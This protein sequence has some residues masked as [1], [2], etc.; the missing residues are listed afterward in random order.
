M[1]I[2]LQIEKSFKLLLSLKTGNMSALF[3]LGHVIMIH[4]KSI[5]VIIGDSATA[6]LR[7]AAIIGTGR[8]TATY[9]PAAFGIRDPAVSAHTLQS[10][11]ATGHV[12]RPVPRFHPADEH[13]GIRE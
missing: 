5:V 12:P 7:R 4:T 11:I 1:L 3:T 8:S 10:S 9:G 6:R 2:R 13:S